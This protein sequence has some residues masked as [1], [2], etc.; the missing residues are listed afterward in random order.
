[1]N[2][3]EL[4]KLAK[5]FIYAV[6]LVPLLLALGAKANAQAF[7]LEGRFLSYHDPGWMKV[8][9]V[10]PESDEVQLL[11]EPE[12]IGDDFDPVA[13]WDQQHE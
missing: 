4:G 9:L 7:E 12:C 2:K 6:L 10:M 1:M 13:C 5:E 3:R 11:Q 8:Q